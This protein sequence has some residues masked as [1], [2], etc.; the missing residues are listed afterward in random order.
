MNEIKSECVETMKNARALQEKLGVPESER[1]SLPP[2]FHLFRN[3]NRIQG[4]TLLY[5]GIIFECRAKLAAREEAEK[6]AAAKAKADAIAADPTGSFLARLAASAK[7]E[8]ARKAARSVWQTLRTC[9]KTMDVLAEARERLPENF[10]R[11]GVTEYEHLF[12]VYASQVIELVPVIHAQRDS[13][14]QA[15]AE[16]DCRMAAMRERIES[17][18]REVLANGNALA[19]KLGKRP[20]QPLDI[21]KMAGSQIEE[22]ITEMRGAIHRLHGQI[23]QQGRPQRR[24]A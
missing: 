12:E 3:E 18:Y 15:Q 4:L 7:L 9:Q 23:L 24:A 22:A 16:Y 5:E 21:I 13:A 19:A 1:C 11:L 8:S 10:E 17:Q 2:T 20:R 14:A 6:V